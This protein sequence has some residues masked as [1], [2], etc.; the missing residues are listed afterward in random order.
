M[1]LDAR[2]FN[3]SVF[4][5]CGPSSSGKTVFTEKLIRFRQSLFRD[6]VNDIHWFYGE[7]PPKLTDITIKVTKGLADGWSNKIQAYDM[8]IIDDL[9]VESSCSKE[10]TNAFTRLAHHRPCSLIYIT[11]NLF[12]KSTDSRTRNLNCHYLIIMRN[13]RDG[14]QINHISRQMFP[15]NSSALSQVFRCVTQ[16]EAFSYL[17]LDFRQETPHT[18]RVRSHIFPGEENAVY[19][20]NNT[21]S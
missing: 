15:N 7:V 18:L 17:F 16:D 21:K 4:V 14:T 3:E 12:H 2:L 1:S 20:I 10:V 19:I 9:F 8:V 5:I 11:Q 6:R 13:P